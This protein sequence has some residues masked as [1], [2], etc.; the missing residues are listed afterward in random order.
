MP[1]IDASR[2]RFIEA[3]AWECR[4]RARFGLE[5]PFCL[6]RDQKC[7]LFRYPIGEDK[8]LGFMQKRREG[9]VIF[10]NSSAILCREIFTFAHELGHLVLHGEAEGALFKDDQMYISQQTEKE[11]DYFASC[12]LVPETPLRHYLVEACKAPVHE[13]I[14]PL[15]VAQIMNEFKISSQT[16]LIALREY[17]L[18]DGRQEEH[19]RQ[20][21]EGKVRKYLQAAQGDDTLLKPQEV[22]R[23]PEEFLKIIRDNYQK[24]KIPKSMAEKFCAFTMT[25]FATIFTHNPLDDEET[26]RK[27][28]LV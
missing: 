7:Y 14:D 5:N 13:D 4:P 15:A 10:T 9:A 28:G 18:I 22:I 2:K 12:L 27:V 16:A 6:A 20:E 26:A 19:L 23:Y 25:E 24:N 21:L 3:K 17:R 11:A 1:M 8:T